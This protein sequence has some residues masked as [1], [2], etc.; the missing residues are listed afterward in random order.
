[1]T[2]SVSMLEFRGV[3][4]GYGR[5]TV[6]RDLTF[7]VPSG[8]V[9]G[10]L[11]ANGVGKTTMLRVAAGLVRPRSGTLVAEGR[12]ITKATP[13]DRARVGLCL[14]PEGRGIF[15]SLTVAENL[16]IHQPPWVHGRD[17][18]NAALEAFPVLG[19]RRNQQAG[20]LSGGEQQMLSLAR[21]WLA[22]P[23]LV[24]VDEASMGLSPRMVDV[25]FSALRNL[26]D[27]GA[28]LLIVEQYVNIVSELA[29]LV[30]VLD[31]TGVRFYG[32][33]AD[34]DTDELAQTYLGHPVDDQKT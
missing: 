8:Q 12:D 16:R 27:S 7:S 21:A 32:K 4:A 11:G 34:L 25:V 6:L 15:R 24:M 13:H 23:K 1:M 28:T 33:P 10:C 22:S 14:I 26:A 29:D 2:D 19:Q 5:S 3:T 17:A 30:L 31:K 9:V 18:F 20:S